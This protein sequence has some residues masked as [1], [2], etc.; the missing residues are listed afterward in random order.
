MVFNKESD[1]EE[2]LIH[3]LSEKGWDN[4]VLINYT[5]E[6]LLRNWADILFKNNR[7]IDRLNNHPLTDDEM[8]QIIE[9]I[10]SLKTPMRLNGF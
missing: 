3:V 7:G 4:K 2:A 9:Q 1:F 5:E 10:E 6:Q 8:H